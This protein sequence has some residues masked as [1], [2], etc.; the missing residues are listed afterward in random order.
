MKRVLAIAF[1]L[2]TSVGFAQNY[3]TS[4]GLRGGLSNGLTIKHFIGDNT[5][6]EGLLSSRWKGFD[7]TGL[8]E[9]HNEAFDVEGLQWYYGG[10]AHIGFWNGKNVGWAN[11]TEN[12]SVIGI[13]GILGLEYT[14][15]E[16]PLNVSVDWKP[17]F[18][19]IGQTGL[20]GDGG[21]LSLRYIF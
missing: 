2:I 11:D 6:V 7:L 16:F 8:Y 5:A 4:A 12:Y 17:A 9:I 15:S 13:D 20:W 10:G 21:A 3:S 1:V 18:N 19:I 14:F